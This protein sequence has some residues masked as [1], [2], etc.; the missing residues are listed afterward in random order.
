MLDSPP[1][2]LSACVGGSRRYSASLFVALVDDTATD[3][4]LLSHSS[5]NPTQPH[6]MEG[7]DCWWLI[8]ANAEQANTMTTRLRDKTQTQ[9]TS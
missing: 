1:A 6:S 8:S 9:R 3:D 2:P 4:P 5:P 7:R